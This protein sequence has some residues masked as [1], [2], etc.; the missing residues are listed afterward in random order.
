MTGRYVFWIVL[1]FGALMLTGSC[2]THEPP[3]AKQARLIA[4]E[5]IEL[6]E[7]LSR[8]ETEMT[9]LKARHAEELARKEQEL[10]ACQ[11]RIETLRADLAKRVD[12]VMAAVMAENARLRRQI[13]DLQAQRQSDRP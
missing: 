7:Q 4:A 8:H 10:A 9:E 12:S 13:Q 6:N 5:N 2:R 1:L 3:D 11:E